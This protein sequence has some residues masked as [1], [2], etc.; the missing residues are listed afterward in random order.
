MGLH[1]IKL[2][3]WLG[4]KTVFQQGIE[5]EIKGTAA[6]MATVTLEIVKD[7]TDGRRVSKLD[8]D[9]G[10]ILALEAT[11]GSK[12]DFSFKIPPYKASTDT[13]TFVFKCFN[14]TLSLK[15]IRCG[16]VWVF[17]GSEF[18]S[19]PMKEANAPAA[20]L[21]R[22]VMSNLRF[23]TPARGIDR[24][25]VE[26]EPSEDFEDACWIK[27]TETKALSNVSSA[28]FSFAYSLADQISYP[29]G[30]IDLACSGSTIINWI[31]SETT[32]SMVALKDYLSQIELY[33]D[34][35]GYKAQLAEDQRRK[36]KVR[37]EKEIKEGK[38]VFDFDF[39]KEEK[40]EEIKKAEGEAVEEKSDKDAP[41]ELDFPSSANST[42]KSDGKTDTTPSK[43][44]AMNLDFNMIPQVKVE[45]KKTELKSEYI[46]AQFRLAT[47]YNIKLHPL[48]G[49]PVRGF[50]FSPDRDEMKF[51]RYDL[52]LMGLMATLASTFEPKLV[53][54]D[55]LMPS[56]LFVGLHPRNVDFDA[57]YRLL[58]FN[59]NIVAFSKRLSMPSGLITLHD[60]LLPDKTVS[61]TLGSRLAVIALGIHFTPKMP[62]SCPELSEVERAGSK[63]ILN[64][65]NE[66]DGLRLK[67]GETE[68]LGFAIAGPDRIFHPA[69]A[70]ILHGV[71]VMVW[72]DGIDNPVSVT[73]GFQPFPH[74]ATFRNLS[75]LPVMPFRFDREPAYFA[76]DLFFAS[77]DRLEF[78]GKEDKDSDFEMLKVYRSFKGNGVISTDS[79]NKTSGSS[80]LFIRYETD[81][82]LYGFEPVLDYASLFA[83]IEIYGKNKITV[84]VF[85]PEQRKKRLKVEG[86]GETE[87]RQQ[88]TWQTLTLEYQGELPIVLESL[89]FIIT[90][91]QSHGEIYIDNIRFT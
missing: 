23:F 83:P 86:F 55:S 52:L 44:A 31:S 63:L 69:E 45:E 3:G 85:N 30:V 1:P 75:D 35:E 72:K 13:Y 27:V 49:L 84:D 79:M 74:Q 64:F 20:P 82:S 26:Y 37:L 28:A 8:T 14:E 61:F 7:P 11:T 58:E 24:E 41:A 62:K 66:G 71:R 57:P 9:Y 42:L 47:L 90:D 15:D 33:L 16:D 76:P 53:Y 68:L 87:I 4:N 51:D 89:R 70:M 34:E 56:V 54:D 25:V 19:I 43:S 6:P 18:L 80:S 40:L 2:P 12:G 29:V 73:Y 36:D 17:L 22:K 65:T 5:L 38:D 39:K 59:E 67:E 77:C 81:K 50:C 60:L 10:V 91:S 78:V 48:K 88:L 46:A 21:K 32:E